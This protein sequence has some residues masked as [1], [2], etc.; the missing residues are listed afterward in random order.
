MT[1]T[2]RINDG[3]KWMITISEIENRRRNRTSNKSLKS[4]VTA[5]AFDAPSGHHKCAGYG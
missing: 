2:I 4:V 3:L 1:Y 5:S